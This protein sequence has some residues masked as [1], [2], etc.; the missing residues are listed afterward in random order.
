MGLVSFQNPGGRTR[1]SGAPVVR[2][3]FTT[4]FAFVTDSS[5][6]EFN[7]LRIQNAPIIQ[8][9]THHGPHAVKSLSTSSAWIDVKS[10]PAGVLLDHQ[11]MGMSTDENVGPMGL[12]SSPNA[13]GIAPRPA[14][15]VGHPHP[16]ATPVQPLV[17]WKVPSHELIVDVSIHSNQR[18]HLRQGV[19]DLE[20][21]DVSS[22]PNFIA[23]RKVM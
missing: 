16:T 3:K 10:A 21:A 11:Q 4:T 18:S 13:T 15:N 7:H 6:S 22:M 9:K 14:T 2:H 20:I 19:C 8:L 23:L 17:L 1:R 5:C 12:K